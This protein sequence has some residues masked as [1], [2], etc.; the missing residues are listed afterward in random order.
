MNTALTITGE[1]FL[2][3][4]YQYI[5]I[6]DSFLTVAWQF[7]IHLASLDTSCCGRPELENRLCVPSYTNIGIERPQDKTSH[8]Q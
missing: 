3:K 5:D 7:F 2:I 4:T 1:T 6:S 8:S